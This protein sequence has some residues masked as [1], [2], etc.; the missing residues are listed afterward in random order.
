MDKT[1][2]GYPIVFEDD[3]FRVVYYVDQITKRKNWK[4][5]KLSDIRYAIYH[6]TAGQ[7]VR[8]PIGMR[9][10]NAFIKDIKRW[11]AIPYHL[12]VPYKQEGKPTVYQLNEYTDFTWHTKRANQHGIG[13]VFQ[14]WFDKFDGGREPSG[15]QKFIAP[16]LFTEY[17]QP[18]FNMKD[19]NLL[20]HFNFTK[21][22][23]PG[24]WLEGL[25]RAYQGGYGYMYEG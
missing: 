8:F 1:E 25:C 7:T 14:G 24:Y 18:T 13:V 20:G 23:C 11:P 5:R 9:M 19:E 2:E 3:D 17:L 21:P 15:V 6:H 22:S 4:K 16:L 12:Y 10:T